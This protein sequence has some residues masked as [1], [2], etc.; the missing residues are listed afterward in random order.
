M[1]TNPE[2]LMAEDESMPADGRPVNLR[3]GRSR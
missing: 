1:N 3:P 2:T